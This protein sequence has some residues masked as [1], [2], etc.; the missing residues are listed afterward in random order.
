MLLWSPNS[1]KRR[2][3]V[4]VDKFRQFVPA[5]FRAFPRYIS[6]PPRE[7]EKKKKC[8]VNAFQNQ[9]ARSAV[10]EM[11]RAMKQNRIT[12]VNDMFVMPRSRVDA[13]ATAKSRQN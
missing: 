12:V 11:L 4:H 9:K 3:V 13:F 1:A 6:I 5:H 2:H 8:F 10:A 7:K